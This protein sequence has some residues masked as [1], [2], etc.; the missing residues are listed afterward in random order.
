LQGVL[1]G[2]GIGLA[3]A[4]LGHAFAWLQLKSNRRFD[5]RQ[6][7]YLEAAAA[8]A[9]SLRFF[10]SV[11][12]LSVEDSQLSNDIH[13]MSVAMFKIHVVGTPATMA[14]LS[15]ANHC[16]IVAA[17]D[18]VKRRTELR[19]AAER[20]AQ[21]EDPEAHDEVGRLH[22][23]L[24]AAALHASLL[25]QRDLGALNVSVRRELGLPVDEAEYREVN[26]RAEQRIV[27]T[28]EPNSQPAEPSNTGVLARGHDHTPT[29]PSASVVICQR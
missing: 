6:T 3:T 20:A 10:D 17:G 19:S 26:L 24:L 29:G 13:P 8:M 14:A 27:N 28:I 25:Y 4:A 21:S 16:L 7:V 5:L 23:E 15:A 11:S 1:I 9:N 22:R 2:G 12:Q 18:L